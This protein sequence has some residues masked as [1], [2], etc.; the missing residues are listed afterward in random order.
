MITFA[1]NKTKPAVSSMWK[2]CF[3]DTDAYIDL[4]FSN[5]YK[6]ENT[7]IYS[8]GDK[9]VAALQMQPYY[10]RM[11][12]QVIPF[13][14]LVGL[15]TL[16][17]YRNR[18][19]MGQLINE[20]FEVM[21]SRNIPLSVLLPAEEWLYGY[22]EKFGFIQTFEKDIR[23]IDLKSIVQE[24]PYNHNEAFEVFDSQ[25][26]QEDFTVLKT[27]EDF[28]VIVK[29]YIADG[30][31]VKYNLEGMSKIMDIPYLLN[32]YAKHSPK[33]GITLKVNGKSKSS[34]YMISDHT[35]TE[36][37]SVDSYDIEVDEKQLTQ[38]IFGYKLNEF[39]SQLTQYFDSHSPILNLML[40]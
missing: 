23:P 34:Y 15:C 40:E 4:I 33:S 31:P 10:I 5:K 11:Y 25:Y 38:L 7:L 35:A 19:Y 36:I 8:E 21:R 3:G 12:N 20:A 37:S 27:K 18:G 39:S 17:E 29:E 22:Y 13:Y 9:A 1:T 24:Y 26:Q 32:I 2:I 16:P 28:K 14:Y 6:N 30:M